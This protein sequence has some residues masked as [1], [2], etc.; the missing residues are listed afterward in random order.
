MTK[1]ENR[2]GKAQAGNRGEDV[3]SDC[4]VEVELRGDGGILISTKS[5]VERIFGKQNREL[6]TEVLR[7]L[8]VEHASL[9]MEDSGAL[10][11]VIA[12]RIEAAV[13]MVRQT[14]RSCLPGFLPAGR[15]E[16]SR[17]RF[18]FSR[19]YLPGNTPKL[20][21]NAGIHHPDGIILD[22]EDSV[23]PGKKSEA[24]ILV[25]NALRQVDFYGA[26]RM[27]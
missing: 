21:I 24:R 1:P 17:E 14:E 11:F 18:R 22:L 2:T 5:R 23:A 4:Y 10:P 25:R 19:L 8:G 15:Y 7:A 9:F 20:M 6:A 3:R 26:E 12:A 16:T 27:V 13:K